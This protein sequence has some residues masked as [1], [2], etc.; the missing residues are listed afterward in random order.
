ML[1]TSVYNHVAS[2]SIRLDFSEAACRGQCCDRGPLSHHFGWCQ[3]WQ[4]IGLEDRA[5]HASVNASDK[6]NA[7]TV[8]EL[9]HAHQMRWVGKCLIRRALPG[10]QREQPKAVGKGHLP[11]LIHQ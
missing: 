4:T 6:P 5:G 3:E 2:R 9:S 11:T 7:I 10:A 1:R 8:A